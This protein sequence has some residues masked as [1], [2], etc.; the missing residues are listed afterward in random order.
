VTR[1][2]D[3]DLAQTFGDKRAA[4]IIAQRERP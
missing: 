1:R 2:P 3:F 4:Q